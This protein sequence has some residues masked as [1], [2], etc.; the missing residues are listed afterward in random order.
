MENT[1]YQI[2]GKDFWLGRH[3]AKFRIKLKNGNQEKINM[4]RYYSYNNF[5]TERYDRSRTS[6]TQNISD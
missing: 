1:I 5:R 4:L 6:R 2:E 3:V